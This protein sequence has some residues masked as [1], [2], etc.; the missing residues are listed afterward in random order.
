MRGFGAYDTQSATEALTSP[1]WGWGDAPPTS[2]D[3]STA[4]YG[5][6][7]DHGSAFPSYLELE[8]ARIGDDGGYLVTIRGDYP[9][10]GASARQRPTGFR[11]VME[12]NGVEHPLYS[13]FV[14]DGNICSTDLRA[15]VLSVYST[16]LPVGDY[17]VLVRYDGV[18]ENV[19]TISVERRAR[20][21]AE[22]RLRDAYP[23]AYAV[24][25]RRLEVDE[26]LSGDAQDEEHTNLA[27]I[28]RALGQSL[29]EFGA[30]GVVTRLTQD[31]APADTSLSLESTLGMSSRGGVYVGAVL[32]H[33]SGRTETTLTG[34]TRPLGQIATIPRGEVVQHDPHIIA[35]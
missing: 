34:L 4:D 8:T 30:S 5:W 27:E 20:T 10:R 25:V 7:S 17:T 14:G 32:I 33:Y 24:G 22:Y 31:L 3:A 6:G 18:E 2:W 16:A 26:L 21:L 28:T 23:S 29:A 19:G 9:R 15:S 11:V 1:D 35:D 13:G 12:L